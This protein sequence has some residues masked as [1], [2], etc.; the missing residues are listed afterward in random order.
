MYIGNTC[1]SA[2]TEDSFP[3]SL[4]ITEGEAI[5]D[6]CWYPYMSASDP[7]SCVFATT[8][9]D[10]PI[11]LWDTTIG[12]LPCTYQAYDNMDDITAAFSISYV[13][14]IRT[15][16][17]DEFNEP[18]HTSY[19]VGTNFGR[20]NK[21][22]A[23]GTYTNEITIRKRYVS[24]I[25]PRSGTSSIKDYM[26][27]KKLHEP[28]AKDKPTGMKAEDWTLLDR[29]ALGAVRLLLAKNVAYNVVNEKTTYGLF[30]ALSYMYEKPNH[31]NEFNSILSR[32]MSVDIKFDDE[33]QALLLLSSLP[34]SW[35][36]IVTTVSGSTGS[37]K[38][39]FDSIRD[40]ILG[41]DIRRKIS[42]EYS[43]SLLSEE[44]KSRG[45]KQ[46]RGQ[47]QNIS[48]S[49]SKKRGQSKNRQDITCWN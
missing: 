10:H 34:E 1:S 27:Q 2:T 9:R 43:N 46:D 23:R 8:T 16:Y 26:Y 14:R 47:K 20:D 30:K 4:A 44:D 17:I 5:Y 21:K 25:T 22:I 35:S 7:V 18:E 40:L 39:K 12:Q 15:T 32:L 49:K 38:L 45:K 3:A 6:Y 13:G 48:R 31:V 24:A 11:H 41:E 29:H 42:G 28:L 19:N 33:V 36:G 37:T